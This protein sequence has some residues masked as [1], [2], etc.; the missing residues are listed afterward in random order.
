MGI[1]IKVELFC[2]CC[3]EVRKP[4]YG[5]QN[6]HLHD[7]KRLGLL[8]EPAYKGFYPIEDANDLERKLSSLR[9]LVDFG[10]YCSGCGDKVA[11]AV[12][13]ELTFGRMK[14]IYEKFCLQAGYLEYGL[15]LVLKEVINGI[16]LETKKEWDAFVRG[17][18]ER[19]GVREMVSEDI[20][21]KL[22]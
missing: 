1:R 7:L 20:K 16:S 15:P 8:P 21:E 22:K 10:P 6:P 11:D 13:K 4:E 17:L 19:D 9:V 14:K 18:K 2:D 5:D 3:G 12:K